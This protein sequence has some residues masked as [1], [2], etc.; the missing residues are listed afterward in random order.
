M[1]IARPTKIGSNTVRPTSLASA[2]TSSEALAG[3]IA[4][5]SATVS[6]TSTTAT[7][8]SATYRPT[9]RDVRL[10]AT[11]L[12]RE[13][14]RE[15]RYNDANPHRMVDRQEQAGD[16][17]DR[18]HDDVHGQNATENE[19]CVAQRGQHFAGAGF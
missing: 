11:H 13:D 6:G 15:Q 3:K 9:A 19:A 7:R 8:I 17:R 14:R 12:G 18:G 10:A 1:P 4:L 2:V 5:K 16:D